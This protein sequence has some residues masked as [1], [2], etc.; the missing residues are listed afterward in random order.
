MSNCRPGLADT[1]ARL[2]KPA[3]DLAQATDLPYVIE[4]V[5]G[6]DLID[7]VMLCGFMFGRDLYRHRLFETNWPL[8]QPACR[9]S[10]P[11]VGVYGGHARV[12]AASAGGRGTRDPWAAGHNVA[13]RQA[14]GVTRDMTCAEV[15]QGIP[16]AYAEY[17]ALHLRRHLLADRRAA[18]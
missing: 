18:A 13:M 9:H 16:P 15:S 14:M 1:Y 7:P 5:V 17:V 3:R 6:S 10:K 4:N 2:I 8:P 11:V 12:R